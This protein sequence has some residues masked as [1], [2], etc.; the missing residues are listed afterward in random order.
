MDLGA[1]K[2]Y[3]QTEGFH[4]TVIFMIFYLDLPL[5]LLLSLTLFL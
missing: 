1:E 5:V 4:G 3:D 2:E